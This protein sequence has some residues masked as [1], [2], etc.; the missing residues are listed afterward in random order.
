MSTSCAPTAPPCHKITPQPIDRLQWGNWTPDGRQF[1]LIHLADD[2]T[3]CATT[4]C[5]VGQVDLVDAAGSGT[6]RTI[7]KAPGLEAIQFRPPDGGEL[8]YRARV[9]GRWGLFA[10]DP[11]GGNVR[12][13]VPPTVSGEIGSKLPKRRLHA[14]RESDLYQHGDESGCCQL[15]VVNADGTDPHEFVHLGPAWDGEAVPSPDGKWIAYWHNANDGPAHGI[16]VVRTDGT[17]SMIETGPK[18]SGTAHWLWSPDSTKI[19]MFPNDVDTGKAYL[20]D[21]AGGPWTTLPWTSSGDLDWQ[22]VAAP[23]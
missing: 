16:A 14:R 3:G 15:W 23:G 2:P 19:L 11:D 12:A 18:L 20:L 17:G 21:P 22:R 9:E 10:M 1:A 7:A 4:I 5:V 6:I 8:L 13:V